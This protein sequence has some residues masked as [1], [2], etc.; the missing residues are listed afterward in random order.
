MDITKDASKRGG[1]S[2][3]KLQQ[4]KQGAEKGKNLLNQGKSLVKE[5]LKQ[6]EDFVTKEQLLQ[7]PKEVRLRQISKILKYVQ[8]NK[9]SIPGDTPIEKAKNAIRSAI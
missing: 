3:K 8:E 7:M 1:R 9:D 2:N 4:L 6:G 5:G